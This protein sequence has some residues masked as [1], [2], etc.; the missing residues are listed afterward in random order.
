MDSFEIIC[1][2]FPSLNSSQKRAFIELGDLYSSW[3]KKINVISRKDIEFLYTHH[4][5]H[6]L[7]IARFFHFQPGTKILDAGTGGGFPGLPLSIL[8]PDVQ[9]HLVDSIGKKL[10]I[11]EDISS[12][13]E[14][15]NITTEHKRVENIGNNNFDVVVSRAV[16]TFPTFVRW[17]H[18]L[19]SQRKINEFRNGIIYLKGGNLDEEL[20]PF[21]K[22]A[23]VFDLKSVFDEPFFQTKK[24]VYL[25]I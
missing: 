13:L 11:I 25:P 20:K 15:N 16:T 6:S 12:K 24:I 7:S 22:I 8:F 3:N 19:I 23:K 1:S 2:Y 5:L 10:K 9:F 14:L 4:I 17:V 18:K 21:R